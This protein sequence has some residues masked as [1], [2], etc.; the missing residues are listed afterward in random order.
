MEFTLSFIMYFLIAVYLA[1]PVLL[2]F[3]LLIVVLGL[4]VGRIEG[5]TKFNSFY[6][7]FITA[8]T[9]GYGDIGPSKPKSKMIAIV[10]ALLG[11]MFTGIVVAITVNTANKAF[12]EHILV[13]VGQ[14]V[15]RV[16]VEVT[17]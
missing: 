1:M 14:V 12:E 5:W 2:F 15:E 10:I 9:V 3:V 17:G 11:I 4:V 13:Q 7:S 6:W 16:S 8:F